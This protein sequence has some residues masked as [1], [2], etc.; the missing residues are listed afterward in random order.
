MGPSLKDK[1]YKNRYF[2]RVLSLIPIK[3]N[4]QH[5]KLMSIFSPQSKPYEAEISQVCSLSGRRLFHKM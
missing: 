5:Q 4:I 1:A 2:Q 3:A